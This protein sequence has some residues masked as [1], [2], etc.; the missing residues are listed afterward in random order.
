MREDERPVRDYGG[1]AKLYGDKLTTSSLLLEP[2]A[3]RWIFLWMLAKA[4]ADGFFRC[5]HS[6]KVLARIAN[7]SEQEAAEAIRILEAPDEYS[8]TP[9]EEGRRIIRVDGGWQLTTYEQHREYRTKEAAASA[10]RMRKYRARQKDR[11]K[12]VTVTPVTLF[13]DSLP[14]VSLSSVKKE[15]S[16]SRKPH[17]A[18]SAPVRASSYLEIFEHWNSQ[19]PL[20]THRSLTSKMSGHMRTRLSK[21]FT[22]TEIKQGISKYAELVAK[23]HGAGFNKWGLSDL[24]SR[25]EGE[26]LERHLNPEYEGIVPRETPEQLREAEK[27]EWRERARENDARRAAAGDTKETDE[28]Y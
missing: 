16:E 17:G 3:T 19:K 8:Q 9:D 24:L 13:S 2:V 22:V 23:G 26:W 10:H 5:S 21:G 4:N 12:G 6:P 18:Q 20:I 7:V 14:S 28:D 11:S 1:F 15:G 25:G 27:A